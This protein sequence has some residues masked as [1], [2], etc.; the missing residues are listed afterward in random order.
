MCSPSPCNVIDNSV[1]AAGGTT[2]A[3]MTG[4]LA[5]WHPSLLGPD[6]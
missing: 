4:Q 2:C 6:A 1:T 5:G 3:A